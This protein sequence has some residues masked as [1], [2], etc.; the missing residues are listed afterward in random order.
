VVH[1]MVQLDAGDHIA[2]RLP[3]QR[4]TAH[5]DLIVTEYSQ[6]SWALINFKWWDMAS[7]MYTHTPTHTHTHTHIHTHTHTYTHTHICR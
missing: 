2:G 1:A 5:I 4:H 3:S 6:E 7:T